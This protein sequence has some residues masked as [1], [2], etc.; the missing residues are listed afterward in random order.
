MVQI[1]FIGLGNMGKPMAHNLATAG[2]TVR[3]YDLVDGAAETVGI[4]AASSAEAKA[5]L[6]RA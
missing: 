3:G 4:R 5:S 1:G 2:H 6:A